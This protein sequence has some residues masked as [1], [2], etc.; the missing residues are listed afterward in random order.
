MA[1]SK[2]SFFRQGAWMVIAT[3]L[4]GVGM[5]FV[6]TFLS[7]KLATDDYNQFKLLLGIV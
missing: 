3:I 2:L 5:T 7:V 4:G 1:D 6:Q